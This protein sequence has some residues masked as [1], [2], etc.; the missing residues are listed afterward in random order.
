MGGTGVAV[1]GIGVAILVGMDVLVG[2]TS[3]AV[4]FGVGVGASVGI[5]VSMGGTGVSVACGVA[6]GATV[7]VGRGVIVTSCGTVGMFT[8]QPA[9]RE[10]ET[11]I[12]KT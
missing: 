11:K 2:G 5:G 6:V 10:S 4:G 3:V 1:G 7:S 8:P 9:T 12:V